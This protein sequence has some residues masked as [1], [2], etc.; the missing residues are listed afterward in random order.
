M[1][2]TQ[3]RQ[4]NQ[5]LSV[6]GF[7]TAEEVVSWLGGVQ[8][9]DFPGA[10]WALALRMAPA[11]DAT[12]ERA[13]ADG[14]ILRTHVLR[15]TWHFVTPAD[16]RWM[17]T[18]T[19]PR[20]HASM[21]YYRRQHGLDAAA[22]K[23]SEKAIARTLSGGAELTRDALAAAVRGAGV[24]LNAGTLYHILMH[25]ELNGCDLQRGASRQAVH[26]RAARRPRAGRASVVSG[27]G[28]RRADA[29][30][31]HEPRPRAAGRFRLVVWAD[32]QGWAR[33]SRDGATRRGE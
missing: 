27:P 4:R 1:N 8:A 23:R 15:P 2:I 17:L 28:A 32:G 24:D 13:F 3:E 33:R 7:K 22:L 9:Q 10:K 21:A 19:A 12:I 5:R 18:L 26:L 29:T 31:F 25:A 16:I 30:L 14:R 11:V 6:G 20:V